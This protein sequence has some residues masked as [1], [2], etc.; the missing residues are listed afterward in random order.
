MIM[1][2]NLLV[3]EVLHPRLRPIGSALYVQAARV[4]LT[5][6]ALIDFPSQLP[7][8]LLRRQRFECV[9]HLCHHR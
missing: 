5:D 6:L 3:N 7:H 9:D 1:G 4:F 2:A 8:V